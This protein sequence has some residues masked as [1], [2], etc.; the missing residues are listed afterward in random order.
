MKE[1]RLSFIV[2][3]GGCDNQKSS[4]I[5]SNGFNLQIIKDIPLSNL[6]KAVH[7]IGQNISILICQ[8]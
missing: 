6:Q 3:T 5:L 8:R 4:G 7:E 2:L 1:P